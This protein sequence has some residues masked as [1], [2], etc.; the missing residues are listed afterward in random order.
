MFSKILIANRGEIAVRIIR[1]CKELGIS[2]VAI[3]S[4]ADKDALHVQ[5]ADQA[6]CVGDSP[7]KDSYLN[8]HNILSA[9]FLTK[10]E[11]VHP[12]FGFL[13][14]NAT[15]ATMCEECKIKFIGPSAATID[16]MGN[17]AN[18]RKVMQAAGVPVIPGSDGTVDS[19][20]EAINFAEI[21]GYPILLKASAGG[22]GKGIRLCNNDEELIRSYEAA[23]SEARLSFS[24]DS[25]YMEKVIT[26]A[27]H[28]E[29]QV[30]ADEH[31]NIIHLGERE[32]SMQIRNQKV[33]E[34]AP[35]P[36]IT[37][38]LRNKLGDTAILAAQACNY[39]NAGTVEFLLDEN[40]NFYFMEMN[41]RIQVEHPITEMIT[42]IDL[43]KEQISI[44]A[45]N[46]LSVKQ[47]DIQFNGH[48]IECRINAS[49]TG[50]IDYVLL[51]AGGPG[52]RV[53]SGIFPGCTISPFYDSMIAKVISHGSTRTEAVLKMKR[54]LSEFMVTGIETNLN[55]QMQILKNESFLKGEYYTTTLTQ[56][57]ESSEVSL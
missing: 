43:V 2:T 23:R 51:P 8:M 6:V 5:M 3:S 18:A 41:T 28:I 34:E 44:A 32:C 48:S 13:S 36:I 20:D 17:K 7:S 37:P 27:R 4:K 56:L 55:L 49:S 10:V 19:V 24:D 12:G 11:A 38:E 33:L 39:A 46:N 16:A 52:I 26:N 15:F 35:S 25:I 30:I 53:D 22:G 54:A 29:V 57:L 31:S 14:E 45:G 1:A 47:E 9:M 50:C 21:Y 42:G 40:N